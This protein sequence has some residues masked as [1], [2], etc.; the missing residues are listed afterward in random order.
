MPKPRSDDTK[1]N[2][3]ARLRAMATAMGIQTAADDQ[4]VKLIFDLKGAA[5][6]LDQLDELLDMILEHKYRVP[7][8]VAELAEEIQAEKA[9]GSDPEP[10]IAS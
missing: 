5:R 1:T 2:M 9:K 8:K 3:A 6:H 7:K 4:T 10:K